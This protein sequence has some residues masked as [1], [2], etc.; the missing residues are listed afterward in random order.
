MTRRCPLRCCRSCRCCTRRRTQALR[1]RR[2]TPSASSSVQ[3][4]S[5]AVTVLLGKDAGPVIKGCCFVK[6]ARHSRNQS[7]RRCS[8][9][10]HPKLPLHQSRNRLIRGS[11]RAIAGEIFRGL[12]V[13]VARH[14]VGAAITR[15]VAR[16]VIDG[17]LRIVVA[18]QFEGAPKAC[19]ELAGSRLQWWPPH[20]N[21][22]HQQWYIPGSC[23]RMQLKW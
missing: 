1:V 16:I 15:E 9:S 20:R 23:N 5:V 19:D 2:Q 10:H 17:G 22:T 13:E 12:F 21:C 7:N 6:V 14:G 18:G 4:V 8:R 11:V 3:A